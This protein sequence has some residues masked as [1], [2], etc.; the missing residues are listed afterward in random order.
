[1]EKTWEFKQ[2]VECSEAFETLKA[3]LTFPHLSADAYPF[4][5]NTDASAHAIK[6]VFSQADR[7][8]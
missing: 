2:N 6:A 4:L 7:E 1:M 3:A 5:H 8:E